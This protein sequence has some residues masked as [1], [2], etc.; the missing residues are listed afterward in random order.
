MTAQHWIQDYFDAWNSRDGARVAAF[1][2][3]DVIYEDLGVGLVVEGR[4]AVVG[5]VAKTAAFSSDYVFSLRSAFQAGNDYAVE[6]EMRGT[7]TGEV[8]GLPATGKTYV[9]R[10]ATVGRLNDQGKIMVNRDYWNMAD[11]LVQVGVMSPPT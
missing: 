8:R 10:I 11:Y 4:D 2:A 9:I 5:A 1:L 3:D 7:N 6:W